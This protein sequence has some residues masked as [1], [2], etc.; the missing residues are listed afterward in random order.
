MDRS[1]DAE[2]T[3]LEA[4]YDLLCRELHGMVMSWTMTRHWSAPAKAE[5]TPD[6]RATLAEIASTVRLIEA[7]IPREISDFPNWLAVW[8]DHDW[9]T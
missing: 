2:T 3:A 9:N 6:E 7:A 5:L 1:R 8:I 4:S